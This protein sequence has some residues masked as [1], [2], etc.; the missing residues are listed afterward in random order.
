MEYRF[1]FESVPLDVMREIVSLVAKSA[2]QELGE[3]GC[4]RAGQR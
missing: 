3:E 1:D 2:S 4:D